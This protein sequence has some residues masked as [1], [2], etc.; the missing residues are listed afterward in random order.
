M[1]IAER[2]DYAVDSSR[3]SLAKPTATQREAYR[4]ASE[5]FT[6]ELTRLRKIVKDELP[7]LEKA[8]EAAGSPWTPG[9]LPEWKEK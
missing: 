2:V 9:R 3:L 4:I 1:S 5:E 8:M 6:E 7:E